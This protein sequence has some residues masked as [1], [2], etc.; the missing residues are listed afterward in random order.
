[1]KMLRI[2][3]NANLPIFQA[4]ISKILYNYMR[5]NI[6]TKYDTNNNTNNNTNNDINNNINNN[7]NLYINIINIIPIPKILKS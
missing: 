5:L 4:H 3:R 6:N 2:K 7:I 1:M